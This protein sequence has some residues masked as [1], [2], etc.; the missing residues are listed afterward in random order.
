MRLLLALALA[1][2]SAASSL[3]I[4]QQVASPDRLHRPP[5]YCHIA[6]VMIAAGQLYQDGQP[7]R[8]RIYR[9]PDSMIDAYIANDMASSILIH[10][11]GQKPRRVPAGGWTWLYILP[12]LHSLLV[13]PMSESSSGSVYLN[14]HLCL[15]PPTQP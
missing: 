15:I 9:S 11:E 3:P 8:F 13:R 4:R 7:V 5:Y 14:I 12:H 2:C 6:H 1:G 10:G